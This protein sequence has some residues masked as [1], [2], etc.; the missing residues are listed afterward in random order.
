MPQ[1]TR[2]RF[3]GSTAAAVGA[4]G[5][6]LLP[7]SMKKALA[8]PPPPAS[9]DQVEHVVIL[10]Q[11]NRSFDSYFGTLSGVRGFADAD[12]L[13][14]STGR[15]VFAQPDVLNPDG[16]ELPFHLDTTKTSA[17][18]IADLSHAWT[19]QHNSWNGGRMDS[20]LP[21]HRAAD[22]GNGPLTMGYFTR[23]DVPWHYALAD[24]FTICDMNFCS[25]FGPT[26]PNR[27]FLMTGTIDPD[28]RNGGP[29]LQNTEPHPYTWTTYPE[30]LEAAG[31]SWRV[32]QEAD[33]YGTN[34]LVHFAQFQQAP[35]SSP[36]YQNGL[37]TRSHT[38]FMDDVRNHRLP[39][40]SW[41]L[42]PSIDSEHP[43]Y[44]PAQ[45]AR[46]VND[47][48][49][50][51]GSTPDVWAKTVMFLTYDENDGF[52]DHIPPPTPPPGTPGEY[53]TVAPLPSVAGGIAGP[54]GLGFR[55]PMIIVSPWSAGGWVYSGIADHTSIIRF[56][57]RR[58]GVVESNIS[59]WRRRTVTDLTAALR[60]PQR[61][62][63]F[64]QLPDPEPLIALEQQEA[65]TLPPPTVPAQQSM[66]AQE[67]GT[68]PH[69]PNV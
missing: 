40:V 65:D 53:L 24:A 34:M 30:R 35:Q 18:A 66:P 63:R 47:I 28:G 39:Q 9:I 20:W 8:A 45:G 32:Y 56:M 25:I 52:F 31:V 2:R 4:A 13:R 60:F 33:N 16:Y 3:L 6:E 54:V 42:V 19:A 7:F 57:E 15:S 61:D 36:L 1:F 17:A 46:Y 55:V 38:A 51:L 5:F 49:D 10:M 44:L 43:P 26:W 29:I 12:V 48:L 11:E 59:A 64:P 58:F 37:V 69:I 68:R 14:L 50:A 21:A 67:P 23:Q 22:G 27:M 41:I 62:M